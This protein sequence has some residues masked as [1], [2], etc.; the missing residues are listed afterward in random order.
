MSRRW[1]ERTTEE[2]YAYRCLKPSAMIGIPI[3]GWHWGYAGR[4]NNARRR[5][6]E[7]LVGGGR[8]GTV[9]KSW[10]D[11]RPRRKVIFPM[12]RRLE[13][14]TRF[15]EWLTIKT[16]MPVYNITWNRTNPR[17]I[18][19]WVAARQRAMRDT[20]GWSP[21]FTFAH[22]LALLALGTAILLGV[23]R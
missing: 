13:L 9:A 2:I 18:P 16:L 5:D 1:W 7:H 12:R 6:A 10:A 22:L 8:Y 20:V 4:T 15:L 14:T 11:R 17:R 21:N 19:P 23:T 3:I